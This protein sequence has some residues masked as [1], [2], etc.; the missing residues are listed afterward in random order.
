MVQGILPASLPCLQQIAEFPS[1]ENPIVYY[2]SCIS[3]HSSWGIPSSEI[4]LRKSSLCRISTMHK[5][6]R[7]LHIIYK[8]TFRL[9][10]QLCK[11]GGSVKTKSLLKTILPAD[12]IAR[13]TPQVQLSQ[14]HCCCQLFSPRLEILIKMVAYLLKRIP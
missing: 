14:R 10:L 2:S 11:E 9:L 1:P 5:S 7:Q 8:S 6:G 4:I 12:L 3:L 13:P